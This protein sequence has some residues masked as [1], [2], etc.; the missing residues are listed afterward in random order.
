MKTADPASAPTIVNPTS[1]IC[2]FISFAFD[3]LVDLGIRINLN[4]LLFSMRSRFPFHMECAKTQRFARASRMYL[5]KGHSPIV[6]TTRWLQRLHKR[7]QQSYICN[8]NRW[9]RTPR[10]H[11][12]SINY[13][14]FGGALHVIGHSGR[15]LHAL[16]SSEW[17]RPAAIDAAVR[18]IYSPQQKWQIENCI[19]R[20]TLQF[21]D[22]VWLR[23]QSLPLHCFSL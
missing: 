3:V 18:T 2:D 12:L 13:G 19:S 5:R 21:I 1:E 14:W 16:I 23:S 7:Y 10:C 4:R 6:A 11:R 15:L 20:E 22:R 9:T 8:G 17:R